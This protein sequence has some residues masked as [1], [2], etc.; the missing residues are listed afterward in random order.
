LLK[1]VLNS[2]YRFINHRS[3]ITH[4]SNH[5]TMKRKNPIEKKLPDIRKIIAGILK[6][7][8]WDQ[9]YLAHKCGWSDSS[10]CVMLKNPNWRIA[11]ILYVG[12]QADEKLY[13]EYLPELRQAV[14]PVSEFEALMKEKIEA[15]A[16]L[17]A[18]REELKIARACLEE[19]RKVV[20]KG[21]D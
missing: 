4:F 9:A 6:K 21:G 5:Q 1:Q 17:Q 20:R 10:F 16:E 11:D 14:M 7:K 8:G 13:E 3:S 18:T 12:Q 2:A 19:L 15:E